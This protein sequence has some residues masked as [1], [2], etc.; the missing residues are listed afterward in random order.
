MRRRAP[1]SICCR[2]RPVV[3]LDPHP[4]VRG[5][6]A[7]AV[8]DRA[9]GDRH[10]ERVG[11]QVALPDGEVDVVAGRPGPVGEVLAEQ[12]VAPRGRRHEAGDLAGEVDPGRM[13]EPEPARPLLDDV[14]AVL[15]RHQAERGRRTRRRRPAA[16]AAAPARRR[17]RRPAFLKVMP[18]TVSEP[19]SNST[20]EGVISPLWSAAV[21]VISLN[22]EPVGY[23]PWVARLASG[24]PLSG[25]W[26]RL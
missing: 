5:H 7:P 16:P 25:S 26:S 11:L 15:V 4:D 8:G 21:E 24:A 10:L 17:R 18:P 23:R 20:V 14:A 19:P 13:A 1:G 9:V 12:A 2:M 3:V 6:D 22:V